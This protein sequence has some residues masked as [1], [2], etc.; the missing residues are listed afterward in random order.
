ML[1]PRLP[2]LAQTRPAE[3]TTVV[4]NVANGSGSGTFDASRTMH[5][6]ADPPGA[7]RVFDR[8]L[9]DTDT[10]VDPLAAHTTILTSQTRATVNV[11][12]T[13]LSALTWTATSEPFNGVTLSYYIPPGPLAGVITLHHGTGG[14]GANFF[15]RAEY[16]AFCEDAAARGYGLVALDSLDR[17]NKQWDP[18][19][20]A[21]NADIQNVQAALSLLTSRGL[22]TA[23]TPRLAL[24]M[25]NGGGFTSKVAYF[26]GYAAAD[27]YCAQA[28][29]GS[30][31]NVPIMWNMAMNDANDN[32]GASGNDQA[33]A[34]FGNVS[35]RGVAASCARNAPAP[36][37]P[38]RFA[39]ISGLTPADSNAIFQSIKAAG[40]L[41]ANN[42][43]IAPPSASGVQASIPPGYFL[44]GSA[45]LDLLSA[46]YTEHQFFSDA[47]HRTLKFFANPSD[48]GSLN[49]RLVN[50]STRGQVLGGDNVLIGGLVI[51]G[52]TGTTKR[53]LIRALGPA[54][55]ASGVDGVLNDPTID[56]Y[57]AAGAVVASS[58]DW[59]S[60]A[61]AV[62]IA[63]SGFAPVDDREP[64]VILNVAPGAYT[65]VVRGKNGASGIALIEAY[66][67]EVPGVA[68]LANVS[69]RGR[70]GAGENVMIGGFVINGQ[71]AKRVL[72][73]ALG[74]SLSASGVP[75][76]L[77]DP[78]IELRGPNGELLA[79]GDDWQ[80]G[81]QAQEI[82][83]SRFVP[84][85]VRDAALVAWLAP[86][87]Y[88]IIIRGKNGGQGVALV[89]AYE[90]F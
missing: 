15:N 54:L 4:V 63:A 12:A 61:Q 49:P 45:I 17:V 40:F 66:D 10:L 42:F 32:V 29:N 81:A 73:R 74:P 35:A 14:S 75:A 87:P 38:N 79:T 34:N 5:V 28:S 65:A 37:Y 8:W 31:S 70:V 2:G 50:L 67:L 62:E 21:S 58:D 24:G 64:A 89:E 19:V 86:G 52:G 36:L 39:R 18:A 78:V 84:G 88:T 59:R 72:V 90:L 76:V 43:L 55:A 6:W 3:V 11:T 46:S 23:A 33:L 51:Q 25:S 71:S 44:Q 68:R 80:S 77:A 53:L 27:S 69:T 22:L 85:D 57:N 56:I 16:R 13:Y 47:N 1:L 48:A 30:I 9:G 60:E 82:L 26:L 20:A 7:G 41:D 83:A